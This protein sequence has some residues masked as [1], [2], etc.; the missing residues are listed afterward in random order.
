MGL[1]CIRRARVSCVVAIVAVAAVA[2]LPARAAVTIGQVGDPSLSNCN[3]GL[4][5]IQPNLPSGTSFTAPGAGT[6]TSWSTQS[7]G[8]VGQQLT[9]K[10]YRKVG[11]PMVYQAVGHAGP[12]TLTPGGINTFPASIPVKAGDQL[13]LHTV[14]PNTRC[15]VIPS[16][17]A[18][19]FVY[20]GDLADG[21]SAA[22]F[23]VAEDAALNIQATFVPDN[24]FKAGK[25]KRN[26]DKGTA[27]VTFNLPNAGTLTGSGSGAKV[28]SASASESKAVQAGT[29]KLKVKAKGSKLRTLDQTGKVTLKLK[30]KYRPTGGDP[31]TRKLKVKLLKS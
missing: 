27:T 18:L 14:T 21:T 30:I 17:G 11:E 15:A 2:A 6:I 3:Q 9:M 31:K 12:Q 1:S 24:S 26:T 8:P 22:F 16:P 4:D 19:L 13:G 23:F 10:M 7:A 28:S 29:A 20:S 25:V 5:L